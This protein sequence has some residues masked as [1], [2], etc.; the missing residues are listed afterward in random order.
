[1]L[2]KSWVERALRRCLLNSANYVHDKRVVVSH[3]PFTLL[4][5]QRF[6]VLASA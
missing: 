5:K 2:E 1:L 6:E 4:H 3:R